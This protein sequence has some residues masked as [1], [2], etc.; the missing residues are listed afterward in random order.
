MQALDK[1]LVL[2]FGSQY[3]QLIARRIREQRVY[4]EIWPC[5]RPI[6]EIR[7][8]GAKAI[9]LS[10]GPSSVHEDG[11]PTVDP[12]VFVHH[13]RHVNAPLLHPLHQPAREH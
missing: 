12:A 6:D 2:D 8:F 4:S 5:N 11:S 13:Q 3:T 9:V 10:G 7:G 1:V